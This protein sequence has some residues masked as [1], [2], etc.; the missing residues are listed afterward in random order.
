MSALADHAADYL[1][2]RRTLGSKLKRQ[3]EELA[4]F[5]AFC[6]AAG[7]TTLTTDL[8]I[9]WARQPEG[10]QPVQWAHRLSAVRGF[11]RYL[12]AIDPATE[13][14]P[15]DVFPQGHR[16][17][18]PY[19]YSDAEV[20]QL[21]DAAGE[22]TPPLR[23]ATTVTVLGLLAATGMRVGEVLALSSNDVDLSDGVITIS[24]AKLEKQRLIPLHP[25][26]TAAL[27]A[28]AE[29]RDSLFPGSKAFF[30]SSV[31]TRLAYSTL[32]QTFNMLAASVGLRT[33]ELRVRMHDLRHRFAVRIQISDVA[34]GASFDMVCDRC[35]IWDLGFSAVAA[36]S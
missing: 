12:A 30:V 10:V 17:P 7:A 28:Y 36:G 34:A 23:A 9:T 8:A 3:G 26:T 13:I 4:Q 18:S 32:K 31:G 15:P 25:S 19:I 33:P 14:P 2:L 27:S 1:R 11:A 21:L 22:L 16:R 35:P 24:E 6:D 5:V 20:Q 29:L